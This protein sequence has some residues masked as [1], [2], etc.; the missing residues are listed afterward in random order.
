MKY[1][2]LH[3][4]ANL[5]EYAMH[6]SEMACGVETELAVWIWPLSMSKHH[7]TSAWWMIGH[8]SRIFKD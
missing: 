2:S 4:F 3:P 5:H 6:I 7:I 8:I 1:Y